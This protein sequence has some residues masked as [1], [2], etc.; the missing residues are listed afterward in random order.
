MLLVN[1]RMMNLYDKLRTF[2]FGISVKIMKWPRAKYHEKKARKCKNKKISLLC[3]N[4]TGGV[5]LHDLGLRF[6]TPTINTG[7]RNQDEFLY[8]AENVG[9]F[10]DADVQ[11]LDFGK[12]NHHA[13]CVIYNNMTIDIV[14]THYSS[15]EEGRRKWIER[16]KRLDLGH[17]YVIYE[18]PDVSESFVEKFSKLPYKKAIISSRKKKFKY[19]FYYGFSFYEKWK[20]GKIL[21]YKSW[22]NVKRYLDDFDYVSFFSN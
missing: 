12:Y 7:I 9:K 22:F 8:F 5:I 15:F 19:D 2:L 20:P 6:D 1:I 4:C 11:E 21:D 17:I 13:G 10:R 16:M 14:F 18:G 3:N